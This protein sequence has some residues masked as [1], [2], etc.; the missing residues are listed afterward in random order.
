MMMTGT[1]PACV[2]A[3]APNCTDADIFCVGLVTD[4]GDIRDRAINQSAWEGISQAKSENIAEWVEY[5]ETTDVREYGKNIAAFAEAGYDVIVTVSSAMSEATIAAANTHADISFIGVDQ[6]QEWALDEDPDNDIPNLVG[7]TF[8]EEQAG[9]L[10]G[11]LAAM[12]TATG[13]VGAVCSTDFYPPV[14]RY[15]EGYREGAAYIDPEILVNVTY[16]NDVQ[17]SDAFSDPVWGA[18]TARAMVDQGVDIVFGAGGETASSAIVAAV[19]RGAFGLGAD[20]DQYNL[21][22]EASPRL[23]SSGIKLIAPA[24]TT[25]LAKIKIAL[26]EGDD[27]PAGNFPGQVG[28]ASFHDLDDAVPEEVKNRLEEIQAG[29]LN[30]EIEIDIPTSNLGP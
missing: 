24:V 21:L 11:A 30:G 16:H 6:L 20:F 19:Q 1:I 29:L 18:E 23:L 22:V 8:P 12:M 7:I 4:G 10:M 13:Q 14:W 2:P 15:C 17:V 27:Q 26:M 5:I 28:Y 25:L 9:F 3:T